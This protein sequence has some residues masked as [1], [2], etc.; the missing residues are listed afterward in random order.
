MK[1]S[2]IFLGTS[3]VFAYLCCLFVGII[4]HNIKSMYV[5]LLLV[6]IGFGLW[7]IFK[8]IKLDN[9][10]AHSANQYS[11][12][13][14]VIEPSKNEVILEKEK[15]E[16]DEY[17]KFLANVCICTS[18]SVI[19]NY[20]HYV[21][22]HKETKELFEFVAK[23]VE[24]EGPF[25]E[26]CFAKH[27]RKINTFPQLLDCLSSDTKTFFNDLS[28]HNWEEY[29]TF[30]FLPPEY[31]GETLKKQLLCGNTQIVRNAVFAVHNLVLKPPQERKAI[32]A[33]SYK[34]L[35]LI[36][37]NLG[38]IDMGGVFA[39][40]NRFNTRA[41]QIIEGNNTDKCFCR[42][43]IDEYG[44]SANGLAKQGFLL[45]KE[46]EPIDE[47]SKKGI[48]ECPICRKRYLIIEKYTGWHIPTYIYCCE[49]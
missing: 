43:L 1:F 31:S 28:E 39:S 48:I 6:P 13:K 41:I 34:N 10:K 4:N 7:Y 42:L 3:V 25:S 33:D 45:I 30:M 29:F 17:K 9:K 12:A 11:K 5:V 32:L 38:R 44:P 26:Y 18:N 37:R 46:D 36:K 14:P 49:I 2:K 24:G 47:Y 19:S 40:G 20:T 27:P 21:C 8:T 15:P 16:I 35:A 22:I 23:K